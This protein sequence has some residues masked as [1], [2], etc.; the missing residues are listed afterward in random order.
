VTVVTPIGFTIE[1]EESFVTV[2][3]EETITVDFALECESN[4]P[5][6]RKTAFW[7]H[8]LG[9]ALRGHGHFDIDGLT[10]CDYLDQIDT[11]FNNHRM[12]P[13][14]V[15]EPPPSD[16][17]DDKLQVA[18]DL[19]NLRGMLTEFDKARSQFM[20][21]LFNVASGKL[22][23]WDPISEDGVKV[24]KAITY[25]DILLQDGDDSNDMLARKLARDINW[26]KLI[27]AGV[28]PED[29][30]DIQYTPRNLEWDLA[31]NY[32]NPFN[33]STTI[34]YEIKEATRVKLRVYD[35]AGR[36]VR[37]LVDESRK[38]DRYKAVWNG[39]NNRGQSVATGVYFYRLEAGSFVST[40]KMVLLK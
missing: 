22:N 18:K 10:L 12:N 11:H 23:L 4:P 3:S 7:K 21:L 1:S 15:Y 25:I 9:V 8:Q 33:P 28:I 17:C 32:P 37:T 14:V 5:T 34:R 35:V 39:T 31:Q 6:P 38:P 36:L 16:E 13:V 40:K 24:S 20:A 2:I 19:F 30:P 29:L 27:D 26:G